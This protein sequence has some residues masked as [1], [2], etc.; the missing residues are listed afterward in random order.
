MKKN[1]TL[2]TFLAAGFI[3]S[4]QTHPITIHTN[5]RV[6]SLQMTTEEFKHWN[7]SDDYQN[8]AKREALIKDVYQKFNDDFDFIFLISNNTTRPPNLTYAGMEIGVSNTVTGTGAGVY[9]NSAAYGSFGKLKSLMALSH[10]NDMLYGS[11]F[12]ELMHNRGIL[13]SIQ[14]ASFN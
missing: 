10:Y 8:S 5:G 6:A 1:L 12:H 7:D 2:L 4:A 3:A 13:I 9:N 14:V 11:S